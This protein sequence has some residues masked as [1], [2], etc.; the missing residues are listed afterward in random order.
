MMSKASNTEEMLRFCT[1]DCIARSTGVGIL[2]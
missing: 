1:L 2:L